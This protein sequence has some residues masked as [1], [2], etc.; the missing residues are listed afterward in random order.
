VSLFTVLSVFLIIFVAEIPDKT[1]VSSI[2]LGSK[3]NGLLVWIGAAIAFSLQV[4]ISVT[5][6]TLV[7]LIPHQTLEI[8]IAVIFLL[9]GIYLMVT[10]EKEQLEEGARMTEENIH[11][12]RKVLLM[13]FG[14]T[15]LGEFGDLTQIMTI[16]LEAKY[17]EPISV[18]FGAFLGLVSVVSIGIV[19]GK[20]LLKILPTD[21]IRKLAG[22]VFIGFFIYTL[23]TIL[24]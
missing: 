19:G 7:A 14:V 4:T 23:Y 6:G 24:R 2:L 17:H 11:H 15:F 3:Y 22:V 8:I 12:F 10:K 1:M 18:A 16:N 9:G 20:S 21:R 13:S 5:L